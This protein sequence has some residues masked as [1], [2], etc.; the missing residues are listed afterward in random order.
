LTNVAS[1]GNPFLAHG[2][3]ALL[4]PERRARSRERGSEREASVMETP[5]VGADKPRLEVFSDYI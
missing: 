3:V 4:S 5:L 1:R 2:N